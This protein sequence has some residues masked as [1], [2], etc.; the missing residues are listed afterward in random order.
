MRADVELKK[1]LENQYHYKCG[2]L[3]CSDLWEPLLNEVDLSDDPEFDDAIKPIM[4]TSEAI[5]K[6]PQ[7]EIDDKEKKEIGFLEKYKRFH[8]VN[9]TVCMQDILRTVW[10]VRAMRV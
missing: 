10:N 7:S 6:L 9:D 5:R 1:R 3:I 2:C 8:P 4:M